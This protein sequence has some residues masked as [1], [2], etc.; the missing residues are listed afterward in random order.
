MKEVGDV[1]FSAGDYDCILSE[2]K[3]GIRH[4][5]IVNRHTAVI[6]ITTYMYPQAIAN[7]EQ[8]A[9]ALDAVR[10]ELNGATKAHKFTAMNAVAH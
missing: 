8:I 1:L 3:K 2:T 7:T 5:C 10:D 9:A 4:Y 6:E